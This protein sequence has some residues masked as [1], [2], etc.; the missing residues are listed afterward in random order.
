MRPEETEQVACSQAVAQTAGA[1]AQLPSQPEARSGPQTSMEI[2]FCKQTAFPTG[3]FQI[4]FE[5]DLGP[6]GDPQALPC[7]GLT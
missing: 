1:G 2:T 3:S 6:K 5:V 4:A 7:E